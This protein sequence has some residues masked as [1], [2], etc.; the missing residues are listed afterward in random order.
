MPDGRGLEPGE[1]KKE[2]GPIKPVLIF[3]MIPV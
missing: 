1:V 3:V 2:D